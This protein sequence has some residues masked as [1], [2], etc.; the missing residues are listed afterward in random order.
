VGEGAGVVIL[1]ELSHARARG[2]RI[3]AELIG[4]GSSF[5]NRDN[6][7]E[8]IHGKIRAM[9]AALTDAGIKKEE[10]GLIS[11]HGISTL[12]DDLEEREAIQGL[13]KERAKDIPIMAATSVLG[14]SGAACGALALIAALLAMKEGDIPA[15]PNYLER[16]TGDYLDHVSG[17]PRKKE[18]HCAMVNAFGLGGQNGVVIVR[19]IKE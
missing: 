5:S 7:E 19:K 9:Q 4:F 17:Q 12:R 10:I 1:E 3:Y 8:S 16:D 11:A 6:L 13:F 18:I 2:A 15:N 14:Y